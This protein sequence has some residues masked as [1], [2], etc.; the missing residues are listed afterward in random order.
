M[1]IDGPPRME[2]RP[3]GSGRE[4]SSPNCCDQCRGKARHLIRPLE[5]RPRGGLSV[6]GAEWAAWGCKG[7]TRHRR[8][9]AQF[10]HHTSSQVLTRQTHAANLAAGCWRTRA[11][12]GAP[13]TAR[14]EVATFFSA[15]S[16][17][18][19]GM[20]KMRSRCSIAIGASLSNTLAYVL[21]P[22]SPVSGSNVLAAQ[23][24][25]PQSSSL[26]K[27]PLY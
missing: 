3:T 14:Q 25:S 11:R 5:D 7:K 4:R 20:P 21:G 9:L 13:L 15:P 18:G 26:I 22:I 10:R 16:S 17:S 1:A 2:A 19:I 27:I 24:C 8:R 23:G 6:C 12:G